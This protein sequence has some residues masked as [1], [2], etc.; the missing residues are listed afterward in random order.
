VRI[1][2][3]DNW[4]R[5]KTDAL[6][7]LVTHVESNQTNLE[8]SGAGSKQVLLELVC[9]QILPHVG[10]LDLITTLLITHHADDTLMEKVRLS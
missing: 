1:Q 10:E 8:G 4:T 9:L 7:W 2:L 3:W 6:D 5:A